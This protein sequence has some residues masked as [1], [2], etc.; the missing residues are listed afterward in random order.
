MEYVVR[1]GR[2]YLHSPANSL[3]LKLF[4]FNDRDEGERRNPE[5]AQAHALDVYITILLTGRADYLEGRRFLSRH[6][7][8][9]IIQTAQSIARS[10]FH[11]VKQ[12]GGDGFFSRPAFTP[13]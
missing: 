9:N 10:K 1:E 7:D 12:G 13:N 4:A 5:R 2:E 3:L 6:E 11:S 8:S